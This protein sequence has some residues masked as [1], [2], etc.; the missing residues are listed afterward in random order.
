MYIKGVVVLYMHIKN[1]QGK[2]HGEFLWVWPLSLSLSLEHW[3]NANSVPSNYYW[4]CSP[5]RPE[6]RA[7]YYSYRRLLWSDSR[8]LCHDS[9]E[10]SR[11]SLIWTDV[12]RLLTLDLPR[13]GDSMWWCRGRRLGYSESF[14][15]ADRFCSGTKWS[16][17]LEMLC[18]LQWCRKCSSI[19][20]DDSWCCG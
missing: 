3:A 1:G 13:I 17:C 12:R 19:L 14:A 8:W 10:R 16:R 18:Y 11:T 5:W 6:K 2:G 20:P 9:D 4:E 15:P 7:E